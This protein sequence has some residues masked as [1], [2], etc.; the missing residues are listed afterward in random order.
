M[1]APGAPMARA[2]AAQGARPAAAPQGRP[3]PANMT[4]QQLAAY[5]AQQAAQQAAQQGAP[6][7]RPAAQPA[8]P[9]D[10]AANRCHLIARTP[11]FDAHRVVQMYRL[12]FSSGN[13]FVTDRILPQHVASIVNDYFIER[14]IANFVGSKSKALIMMPVNPALLP[15]I[16]K[17]VASRLV[18]QIPPYQEPS[19]QVVDYMSKVKR[20]GIRFAVDLMDVTKH[21]WIVGILHIEYVLINMGSQGAWQLAVFQKLKVKAPW[22]KIIA[23]GTSESVL[24]KM[25]T[26]YRADLVISSMSTSTMS[27]KQSPALME[28]FQADIMSLAHELFLPKINFPIFK[29]YLSENRGVLKILIYYL[30]RFKKV[31]LSTLGNLSDIYR[32]LA[33]NEPIPSFTTILVH[34]LLTHYTKIVQSS[35]LHVIDELYRRILMH[36][37]FTQYVINHLPQ[38]TAADKM[39]CFQTGVFSLLPELLLKTREELN[40]DRYLYA[41]TKRINDDQSL[42]CRTVKCLEDME[43]N[44]LEGV[45]D[46]ARTFKVPSTI[47]WAAY[48]DAIIHANEFMVAMQVVTNQR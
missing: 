39:Y 6:Q 23:Y 15:L 43:V 46:Y 13:K 48:E 47:I 24:L 36:G 37:Y 31:G 32:Y 44:N 1:R 16:K 22:L 9:V 3:M 21:K 27:F 7:G 40:A 45:F 28:P 14:S 38:A 17:G 8:A 25:S 11:V 2:A 34:G 20:F 18:L 29:K 12:R 4:P 19:K 35:S 10:P 33:E 5:R 42:V 30:H 41:I 26:S